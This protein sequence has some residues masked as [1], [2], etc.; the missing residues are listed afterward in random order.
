[1][2][3][4][5]ADFYNDQ[6]TDSLRSGR[7]VLPVLFEYFRPNSVI[8]IG[9][10]IGTWLA[11]CRELGIRNVFGVD[12]SYVPRNKLL[13][14]QENFQAADLS[15][16]LKRDRHFD[17]VISLE[18]AEHLPLERAESFVSDLTSLA[19]V[20]LFSAAVPY[21]GGTGHVNENWPEYWAAIFLDNGFSAVDCLRPRLWND[22]GVCFWYR[23]N[24]LVFVKK[25]AAMEGAFSTV[26]PGKPLA[27]IHPEQFLYAC[28]RPGSS[29]INFEHDRERLFRTIEAWKNGDISS[30]RTLAGYGELFR[31]EFRGVGFVLQYMRKVLRAICR[32]MAKI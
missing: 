19:D 25:G 7:I 31:V 1:M 6:A 8:D 17:L 18:V 22:T 11:A 27:C 16:P 26:I 10:G 28:S 13:I 5:N 30:M 4:Y 24:L 32:V 12:G 3:L 29:G 2:S 23:Q 21:Q 20:V 9:C 15:Q 14:P